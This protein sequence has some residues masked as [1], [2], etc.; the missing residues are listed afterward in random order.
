MIGLGAIVPTGA[1]SAPVVDPE[2]A[3]E[4]LTKLYVEIIISI[5]PKTNRVQ[6]W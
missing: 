1:K 5:K 3:K 6:T 2:L 4:M